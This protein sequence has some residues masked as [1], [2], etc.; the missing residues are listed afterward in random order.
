MKKEE[1]L[2][3][4]YD[5]LSQVA[6]DKY[7]Y[8]PKVWNAYIGC[9]SEETEIA[10]VIKVKECEYYKTVIEQI[11]SL[12]EEM[13]TDIRHSRIYCAMPRYTMAWDINGDETISNGTLVR[14]LALLP[15]LKKMQMNVLYL[16]PITEYST[17]N[18]K[19]DMGS[20]FAIKDF[21]KLDPNLHDDLVDG[22]ENFDLNDEFHL[23]VEAAHLMGIRIVIDF[24]PRVTARDSNLILEHPE[25]FYWIDKEYEAD[26]KT[27]EIPGLD[28]FE[29]CTVDNIEKVYAADST[30]AHLKHFRKAPNLQDQKKWEDLVQ[31]AQ[32]TGENALALIEREFGITTPPAHSDW[33]NDVQPIWTDITFWKLYMDNNPW[34][35][36]CT[37]EDQP[38]YVMF[39]TIKTNKFPASV[40]NQQLW[41]LFEDV[42]KYYATEF[43]LDG[44][45]FDIGHTLPPALLQR[46]FDTVRKYVENPIFISEDLFNRNHENARKTGYNIMLG[47]GWNEVS[48]ISKETYQ[49]FV[50][51]LSQMHIMAYACAETHDTPR[52][53]TRKGGKKLAKSMAIVNNF[54]PNGAH[55]ILAGYEICES[56][57]MNC[58]LADNTNGAPIKKA[59][60]NQMVMDWAGEDAQKMIEYLISVNTIRKE[61]DDSL[62]VTEFEMLNLEGDAIGFKYGDDVMV[63]FNTDMD[64][65]VTLHVP[66]SVLKDYKVAATSF[67]TP[68]VTEDSQDIQLDEGGALLLCKR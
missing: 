20:P 54:L 42:L 49:N 68:A 56:Q 2:N 24:I 62:D 23:L 26:F 19:G 32:E 36:K 5:Y 57:P 41:D 51:E 48:H 11:R 14:M 18:Q 13:D 31:T 45:R 61:L 30:K 29:E 35:A 63:F 46:L 6:A 40:P 21:Y 64:T 3:K 37:S 10:N 60:F 38:D 4:F 16:L 67:K 34:A 53:V 55:F 9:D 27:P 66:A 43:K 47:S 33:I 28:F 25:W 15:I 58:G 7:I 65:Q 1:R 44:F 59:F 52:I 12:R 17:R 8:I 39:D 22:M 50:H